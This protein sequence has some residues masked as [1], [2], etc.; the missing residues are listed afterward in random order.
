MDK[1]QFLE[2]KKKTMTRAIEMELAF[3]PAYNTYSK[4]SLDWNSKFPYYQTVIKEAISL[5][6]L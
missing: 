6:K 5:Q 4:K 2:K 1:L 3:Q